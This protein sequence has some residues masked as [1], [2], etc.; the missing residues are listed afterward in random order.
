MQLFSLTAQ[1]LGRRYT[2]SVDNDGTGLVVH[3]PGGSHATRML[4]D[5][6]RLAHREMGMILRRAEQPGV[7]WGL[8]VSASSAQ[9]I[10]G[11][12][13]MLPGPFEPSRLKH[14]PVARIYQM[15]HDGDG[16]LRALENAMKIVKAY[17]GRRMA[18]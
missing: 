13:P 5:A 12:W 18:A 14:T 2:V 15:W 4:A 10:Y 17:V 1:V 16:P 8:H 9:A 3:T 11:D 6:E 7:P